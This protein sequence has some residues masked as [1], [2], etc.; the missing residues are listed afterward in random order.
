MVDFPTPMV[1][2]RTRW[3]V[4]QPDGRF[5]DPGGQFPDPDGRFPDPYG[6]FPDTDGPFADPNG[7]FPKKTPSSQK[8]S[9]RNSGQNRPIERS[10]ALT[11]TMFV[12]ISV[13][14]SRGHFRALHKAYTRVQVEAG[15]PT[16]GPTQAPYT[17]V[18]RILFK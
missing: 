3:S 1:D 15:N 18:A 2:F 6:R 7:R 11:G 17:K 9:H 13:F 10:T 12:T 8:R 14:V 16:Q 4:S 5:P